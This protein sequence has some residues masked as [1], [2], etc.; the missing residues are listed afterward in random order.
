MSMW[1]VVVGLALTVAPARPGPW[2]QL[3]EQDLVA[4]RQAILESHP[5]P[6]D[7]RNP[8]FK[9]WLEAGYRESMG[10]AR[11][12]RS[13]G[14]YQAALLRY[15]AGFRDGHLGV[16]ITLQ[17][18]SVRW[19]G[20]IV[21]DRTGKVVVAALDETAPDGLPA[22]GSELLAC[23]GTPPEA[24]MTRDILPY[25]RGADV[26]P[27][28]LKAATALLAD[29]G[30]PRVVL[31]KACTFRGP[32]GAEHTVTLRYR[33]IAPDRLSD[34]QAQ[35]TFGAKPELGVQRFGEGGVWV[36]MPTFGALDDATLNKLKSIVAQAPEWK[37]AKTI[38]FDVRGNTGG[39][40]AWGD[41][42]LEG[43]YGEAYYAARVR[44]SPVFRSAYVEWRVSRD[45]LAHVGALITQLTREQ[46][47]DSPIVKELGVLQRGMEEARKKGQALYR[48]PDEP[49]QPAPATPPEPGTRARVFLLTD[50]R[51]AS[52]CLD[53]ADRVLQLPGVTHVGRTTSAD[54][55][56]MEVR[57][58]ELPGGV[59]RLVLPVK[60]YRDRPRGH[61]V[62]YVPKVRY[63]GEPG[64]TAAVRR[65]IEALVAEGAPARP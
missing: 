59:A 6:V 19:P 47:A 7:T 58:V 51:C 11:E 2:A 39:S 36:S 28:H 61:N 35:V 43:L 29:V 45:N 9:Q 20:F 40:S 46:G 65:W 18:L 25:L 56:F 10:L 62:P 49:T 32:E 54:S 48:E 41:R 24:M 57:P 14:G 16:G 53:F 42:L 52:A 44:Q 21:A 63:D 60:V 23:D 55:F 34:R 5:G 3:A 38:V 27:L 26:E 13:F 22:L 30:N 12:A 64:D 4:M 8:G 17:P 50:G 15:A 31:P 33:P 37:D 1:G